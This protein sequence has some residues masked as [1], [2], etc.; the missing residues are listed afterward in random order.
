MA[1]RAPVGSNVGGCDRSRESEKGR[2]CNSLAG[3][4]QRPC[5][6]PYNGPSKTRVCA[7][8]IGTK[9]RLGNFSLPPQNCQKWPFRF[10]VRSLFDNS[11]R[12]ACPF[13]VSVG[14]VMPS[15][16]HAKRE[17]LWHGSKIAKTC[18]VR[19]AGNPRR[20]YLIF[21]LFRAI[22]RY[23]HNCEE[24]SSKTHLSGGLRAGRWELNITYIVRNPAGATNTH[25]IVY[26]SN[27]FSVRTPCR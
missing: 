15:V 6:H 13:F 12:F 7:K 17:E 4:L 22:S 5:D 3:H 23:F 19:K 10:Q 21:H 24:L 9:K 1:K 20:K 14:F 27:G 16:G 11:S 2:A 8:R 26:I 25:G 18:Q